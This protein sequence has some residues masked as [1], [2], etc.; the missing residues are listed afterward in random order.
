MHQHPQLGAFPRA[1]PFQ[2]LAITV[3]IAEGSTG[4]LADSALDPD[5]LAVAVVDERHFR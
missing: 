5:R 2:H 1:S 4:A 3:G